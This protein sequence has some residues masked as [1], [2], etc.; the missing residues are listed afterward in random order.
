MNKK[1][2]AEA[3]EL[4][5]HLIDYQAR[6]LQE[7]VAEIIK[8]CEDRKLYENQR[9]GLPYAE[10]KCLLLFSGERYLTVKSISQRLDVAKSRVTKL[11][12][13]LL[14]KGYVKRVE[15][16]QDTRVKLIS[17]TPAGRKKIEDVEEFHLYIHKKL[18]VQMS[19]EDRTAI[20]SNLETLRTCMEAVKEELV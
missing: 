8:C 7:L 19:G 4:R 11:V 13:G 5:S 12:N 17:L 2:E 9:F 14:R 1:L 6:R 20:L 18:V 3:P 16:P 15:D 10:I